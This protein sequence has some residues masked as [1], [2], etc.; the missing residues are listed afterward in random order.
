MPRAPE[1]LLGRPFLER[2]PLVGRLRTLLVTTDPVLTPTRADLRYGDHDTSP[3]VLT[4][5]QPTPHQRRSSF[6]L[7]GQPIPLGLK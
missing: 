1:Y 7:L 3:T 4:L 6:A 2:D 5:A